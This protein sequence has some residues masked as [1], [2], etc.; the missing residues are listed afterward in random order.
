M[1]LEQNWRL[2]PLTPAGMFSNV[3]SVVESAYRAEQNGYAFYIDWPDSSYSKA[4]H[5]NNAWEVFF[6]QSFDIPKDIDIKALPHLP[7]G[8]AVNCTVDNIITPHVIH[9][10]WRTLLPPKD[11]ARAGKV[12]NKYIKPTNLITDEIKKFEESCGYKPYVG[13]HIRGPE[14]NSEVM[15]LRAGFW[16]KN[17]VPLRLYIRNL[18]NVLKETGIHHVLVCS[19]SSAIIR[20]VQK[21][22]GDRVLT[23]DSSRSEAGGV[24]RSKDAQYDQVKLGVDVVVEAYL[25][26]KSKVLVHGNSNIVNF[27]L[28]KNPN[29]RSVYVYRG[30]EHDPR[31]FPGITALI[32]E[33]IRNLMRK[34]YS[35]LSHMKKFI[36]PSRA[37]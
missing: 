13:L 22:F 1:T 9:G 24:H 4:D 31:K 34:V 14:R 10:N 2:L 8:P 28:C 3:N 15:T 25:L 37:N 21:Q 35:M 26:S 17:G 30:V 12:I 20:E 7:V 11:R 23:Y 6:E 32:Y 5:G 29:M 16:L 27:A 19:D 36:L 33:G 18:K